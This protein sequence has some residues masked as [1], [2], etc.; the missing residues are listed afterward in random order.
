[1]QP[2]AI[3]AVGQ[4]GGRRIAARGE[5]AHEPPLEGVAQVV[6]RFGP[7]QQAERVGVVAASFGRLGQRFQ[8]R[9]ARGERRGR[10]GCMRLFI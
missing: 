10:L 8:R 1:M 5:N 2:E 9:Q 7:A 3:V 4:Q 6:Q